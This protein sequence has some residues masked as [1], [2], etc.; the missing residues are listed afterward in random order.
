MILLQG[1]YVMFGHPIVDVEGLRQPVDIVRLLS[2]KV[3]DTSPVGASPGPGQDIPQ[4][5]LP[6]GVR[7]GRR[8]PQLFNRP[9]R[10]VA[11]DLGFCIK[12]S[13]E[14]TLGSYYSLAQ[15]Y[16]KIRSNSRGSESLEVLHSAS[17]DTSDTLFPYCWGTIVRSPQTDLA[18]LGKNLVNVERSQR[19]QLSLQAQGRLR[20][21]AGPWAL[22]RDAHCGN[23]QILL[24]PR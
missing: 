22:C 1:A 7:G 4:E 10:P 19:A 2:K 14:D 8:Q 20:P 13:H 5:T 15:D 12:A 16:V 9:K 24:K 21:R 11:R 17:H 18:R 3:D 23:G 6:R